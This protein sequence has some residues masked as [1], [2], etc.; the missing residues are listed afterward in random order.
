MSRELVGKAVGDLVHGRDIVVVAGGVG[1]QGDVVGTV[2]VSQITG[3][4]YRQKLH[5][6]GIM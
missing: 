3:K 1:D 5:T 4:K 6:I 2:K